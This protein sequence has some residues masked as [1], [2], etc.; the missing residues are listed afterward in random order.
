VKL[1]TNLVA[2]VV[3]AIVPVLIFATVVVVL[4]WRHERQTTEARLR[5]TARALALAVDRELSAAVTT[6]EV[7]ATSEYLDREDLRAFHDVAARAV[8]SQRADGWLTIV[9][10]SPD[11]RQLVNPARPFGAPLPPLSDVD[12]FVTVAKTGRPAVSDL[13]TGAV[14]AR[15]LISV[16]V[17]VVRQGR[18][19]YVLS[20]AISPDTFVTLL[21]QQNIPAD[22]LS[23]V[24]DRRGIT[25]ART[26]DPE[27]FVGLPAGEHILRSMK[28]ADEGFMRAVTRD[29][30]TVYFAYSRAPFS[31]WIVTFSVPAEVV[32]TPL[33]R[34]LTSL[35]LG[36]TLLTGLGVLLAT[37][38]TR[39]LARPMAALARSAAAVGR[40]EAPAIDGGHVDEVREV[41]RALERAAEDRRR[42]ELALRQESSVL[43][44]VNRAGRA[45]SA[46]LDPQKVVQAVT[47]AATAVTGAAFGAFFYNV[48]D[49]RGESYMLYAISGVPREAFA[50]FPM[51]RNTAL[52]GPT[53]RGEPAIRLDDVRK[54][55]RYGHS[56]PHFG[57]P[58]GHLPVASYLAVPVIAR[59]GDVLGGLF[60]G[61]PEPGRFGEREEQVV[62]GLAAQAAIAV[63]NARLYE[64]EHAAR[65]DAEAANRTKDEFLATLS[66]ELRT[67]LNAILGWARMLEAGTMA[68]EARDKAL[69]VIVRNATVQSQLIEDLLDVSRIVTGK[70]KLDVRP[71]MLAPIVEAALDTTRP[72]A[73]AKAIRVQTSIDPAAGPVPGD[74]ERLQQVVWNLLSNAVKFTPRGGRIEVGVRQADGYA[75]IVVSD[76]GPG[77]PAALL[78]VIF[79]RFRQADSSSRRAHGGLGIGLALV[80]HL[81][82]LHGGTVEVRSEGDGRGSTFTV[83]LPLL[84]RPDDVT[85]AQSA[86]GP[87]VSG[88]G[89]RVLEGLKI[90][91]VDDEQDTLQLFSLV[92][93]GAGA[94]TRM[95]ASANAARS[96]L[97]AWR[98]DVLVCDIEMPGENGYELIRSIR[99]AVDRA[100]ATIPAVA[101]TAYGRADDRVR[102]LRA[103]FQMQVTKPVEP[104]EL[105]A[106]IA[107]LVGRS[108][109]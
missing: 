18:V 35:V 39:R 99:R 56:A 15:P 29:P 54:D 8:Q 60:F 43:D 14:L 33:Q 52:F 106:V 45:L 72:A 23:S 12:E 83:R 65:R 70:L 96:A 66:H 57:M 5:N 10:T 101:V 67:P 77:I 69:S 84:I 48:V 109:S 21:R 98:A 80:R 64:N 16:R 28:V 49:S 42:T 17:P 94:Q 91:V 44:A 103:G 37:A 86:S 13:L 24:F 4:L 32:D 89:G 63:D 58:P 34:S 82:E 3:A 9:L 100:A 7:L 20:A 36:G 76:T 22:W 6:L 105:V 95:V 108:P 85:R 88:A 68:P 30:R 2:L 55:P 46:E 102:A 104:S 26:V 78:P 81:T 27:R 79:D 73:E 47:D 92:L 40:G 93:A 41:A 97:G 87:D 19:R 1:R 59:S 11:G 74:P 25:I 31:S 71:V 90:L 75:E 51:P 50:S 53:F 107:R 38:L 61:H 62:S